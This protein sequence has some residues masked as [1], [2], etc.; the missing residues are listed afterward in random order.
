M[1]D[2]FEYIGSEILQGIIPDS[3]DWVEVVTAT[4]TAIGEGRLPASEEI[5]EE[6]LAEMNEWPEIR[7]GYFFLQKALKVGVPVSSWLFDVAVDIIPKT[8][9]KSEGGSPPHNE[10]PDPS[11][12]RE[13]RVPLPSAPTAAQSLDTIA[14]V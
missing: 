5:T 7:Q 2:A 13:P 8:P 4:D 11:G 10:G 1:A 14:K 6:I 3:L 12:D 9:D